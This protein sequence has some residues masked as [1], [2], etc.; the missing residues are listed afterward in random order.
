[1]LVILHNVTY[2]PKYRYHCNIYSKRFNVLCNSMCIA[3]IDNIMMVS[4]GQINETFKLLFFFNVSQQSNTCATKYNP[5]QLFCFC[6]TNRISNSVW[7]IYRNRKVSFHLYRCND[8]NWLPLQRNSPVTL[9]WTRVVMKW[10]PS[11][12]VPILARCKLTPYNEMTPINPVLQYTQ[13]LMIKPY[14]VETLYST[15]YHSKYFIE[16]SFDKSSQYVVLWTHK[17]HSI[18]RP[19]GRAMECL[20]WVLQQ[21]LTVL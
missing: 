2:V 3:Y 9:Q 19:F 14:T 21:K 5:S 1:M 16:L 7:L 13:S 15:I 6:C 8:T 11:H 10:L 4:S 17:R 18:P 12:I 20:L